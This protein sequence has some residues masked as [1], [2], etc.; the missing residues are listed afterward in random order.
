MCQCGGNVEID[1]CALCCTSFPFTLTLFFPLVLPCFLSLMNQCVI[2]N[3]KGQKQWYFD[4]KM[5][6]KNKKTIQAFLLVLKE[7]LQSNSE[8]LE[9]YIVFFF[10][11]IDIIL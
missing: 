7:Y 1:F 11:T 2:I 4:T 3:T 8:T 6:K 5:I 10:S 9:G